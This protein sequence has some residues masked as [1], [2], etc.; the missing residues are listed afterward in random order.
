MSMLDDHDYLM[1][2]PYEKEDEEPSV[3]CGQCGRTIFSGDA[4]YNFGSPICEN[5][6]EEG[7]LEVNESFYCEECEE[8]FFGVDGMDEVRFW[9][10]DGNCYCENCIEDFKDRMDVFDFE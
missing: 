3:P 4:F 9:R 7:S 5:C 1:R 10:F 6:V 8:Q 2:M